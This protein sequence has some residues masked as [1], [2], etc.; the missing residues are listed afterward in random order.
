MALEEGA[1]SCLLRSR[2]KL[3]QDIK[4]PYLMDHL[5]SDG[6]VTVDEEERIRSQVSLCIARREDIGSIIQYVK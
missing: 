4:P 5:I 1:R 3:E 2:S 6:V